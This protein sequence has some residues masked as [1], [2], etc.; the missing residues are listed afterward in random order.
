MIAVLAAW[1]LIQNGE[2]TMGLEEKN[3]EEQYWNVFATTGVFPSPPEEFSSPDRLEYV[4]G[5]LHAP[6]NQITKVLFGEILAREGALTDEDDK[7][8]AEAAEWIPRMVFS[9]KRNY[10]L[11]REM[12]D[13][14][15]KF[16]LDSK[17]PSL[18]SSGKEEQGY[19]RAW[20]W[21]KK[22]AEV[23]K[24]LPQTSAS[25]S[26]LIESLRTIAVSGAW[27]RIRKDDRL[28]GSILFWL[29]KIMEKRGDATG[30]SGQTFIRIFKF[31]GLANLPES[32]FERKAI[33]PKPEKGPGFFPSTVEEIV[34][35]VYKV[36]KGAYSN[37]PHVTNGET[38]LLNWCIQ[39][40]SSVHERFPD[41]E[42]A[43]FRIGKMLIWA[44]DIAT[45]KDKIIP[46][47]LKKQTEFWAWDLLGDLFPEKRRACVAMGLLCPAD[48]KYTGSLRREADRLGLTSLSKDALKLVADEAQGILFEQLTPVKGVLVAN[49]KNKEGKFRVKFKSADPPDPFPVSPASVRLPRGCADGCPVWLYRDSNAPEKLL[50]VKVRSDGEPWD[51][52][53][54]EIVA[55][56]RKSKSGNYIFVSHDHEYTARENVIE[57]VTDISPGQIFSIRYSVRPAEGAVPETRI[58]HIARHTSEHSDLVSGYEGAICF[59]G[60]PREYGFVGDIYIPAHLCDLLRNSGCADRT[61]IR[62]IY[63]TLPSRSI[64]PEGKPGYSKQRV[65]AV[66]AEI[67]RGE[68][69]AKYNHEHGRS[70]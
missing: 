53:H 11:K 8:V 45:A 15:N 55:Y 65:E 26:S 48:D 25:I 44:G 4:R 57:K 9:S 50:A 20:D 18:N 13:S 69:L 7:A 6:F 17:C 12:G 67:L 10:P 32:C 27:D 52:M 41:D 66:T 59:R 70:L 34:K 1:A 61:P 64:P 35:C 3:R 42:W 33:E 38:E 68:A 29:V 49:Y 22:A 28:R 54:G 63:I 46:V 36:W 16:R 47:I 40:A 58:V 37:S 24:Q 43:D 21:V 14:F 62:G 5:V 30:G 60:S 56:H 2:V 39:F 51:I 23:Y 31:D 19:Q